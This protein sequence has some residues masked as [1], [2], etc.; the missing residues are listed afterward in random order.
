MAD[1]IYI[2]GYPGASSRDAVEALGSAEG[3]ANLGLAVAGQAWYL[4]VATLGLAP[5]GAL[6][7]ARRARP[8]LRALRRGGRSDPPAVAALAALALAGSAFAISCVWMAA[9]FAR[10]DKLVYGRYNEA[11]V[12]VLL[13]AGLAALLRRAA[14]P[15]RRG[16]ARRGGGRGR[17]GRDRAPR[18]RRRPAR[19]AVQPGHRARRHAAGARGRDAGDRGEPA[20]PRSW[21]A[22]W[23]SWPRGRRARRSPRWSRCS[24][25]RRSTSATA[26]CAPSPR[27][28]TTAS[29]CGRWPATWPAWGRSPTTARTASTRPPTTSRCSPTSG[30]S[31]R[32]RCASTG[33]ARASCRRPTW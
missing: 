24:R 18:P 27:P 33:R 7:L 4:C 32:T 3:W 26:T 23:R 31:T 9:N 16:P 29:R 21:S 6:W 14:A 17:V 8:G 30:G 22:A 19:R 2:P 28:G 15:A 13:A 25:S 20:R 5:I 10:P 1:R 12:A 11:F